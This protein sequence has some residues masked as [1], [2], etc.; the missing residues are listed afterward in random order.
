[1]ATKIKAIIS[2][3]FKLVEISLKDFGCEYDEEQWNN[4]TDSE[5]YWLIQGFLERKGYLP[6]F[7]FSEETVIEEDLV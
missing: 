3:P 7:T 5:K 1:M 6:T 2:P 4:Y